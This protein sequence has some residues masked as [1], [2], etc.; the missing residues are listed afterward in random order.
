M[1]IIQQVEGCLFKVPRR[2]F[3]DQSDV[4][5]S[6]FTLPP[7]QNIVV[8]GMSDDKPLLLENIKKDDFRAFLHV[9][10]PP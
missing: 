7:G 10:F 4:F 8:D 1:L 3:E 9:L 2:P 6:M 5:K